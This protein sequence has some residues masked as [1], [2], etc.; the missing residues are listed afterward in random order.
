MKKVAIVLLVL[1]I[2]AGALYAKDPIFWKRF[3]TLLE[4]KIQKKSP[5]QWYAPLA[6]VDAQKGEALAT[7]KADPKLESAIDAA[8]AYV[9]GLNSSAFMV[10]QNGKLLRETYFNSTDEDTLIVSK[11]MAKPLASMLVARAIE[12]GFI[13][14][15]DQPASDFITEWQGKDKAAITV[16]HLLN[17]ASGLE[18]FYRNTAN[19]FS[20]FHQ[21]FLSSYHDEYIVNKVPLVEEPGSYYDYSQFTSDIVAILIERAT[22][23]KYQDYLANQLLKPIGAAGGDIWVNREGGVAHSGCCVM[24]PADTWLRLG[25]LLAQN[26]EWQGN[27]LLPDWWNAEILKGS[28]NNPNYGLYFWTGTPFAPRRHFVDPEYLPNPGI[29]QSQPYAAE[30]LFMFDGNGSQVI[31]I[32]P[33]KKLVVLRTGG[34]PPK[35]ADGNEWDNTIVPNTILAALEK[36]TG[37]A[38]TQPSF[39]DAM[40]TYQGLSRVSG[41]FETPIESVTSSTDFTDAIEHANKMSSYGLLVWHKGALKLEHYADGY[42]QSLRPETASMHK[43]VLAML[44]LAAVED[45][46]IKSLDDP[47]GD[48][49]PAWKDLPQGEIPLRSLLTMSSGLKPLSGEGGMNSPR[50]RFFIDGKNARTTILGLEAEVAWDSRFFYANTNSQLLCAA[51]EAA[52][53][54]PYASYLSERLWKPLGAQDAY[55]WNNEADGFPRTYASLLARPRDWLRLGLLIKDHGALAGEQILSKKS[56]EQLTNPS[57]RN[58]NY[59]LHIWLGREYEAM[60][61]YNDQNTGPAFASKVPFAVDDMIYFDGIGGQR[62]YVSRKQDLVI[63]RVGDMRFDWDDTHLPNLVIESLANNT[64]PKA[65]DQ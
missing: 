12:Q 10:W 35:D 7:G 55:V 64:K 46:F 57:A 38:S 47:I 36:P 63:V 24:L 48:Y 30:D 5:G 50:T 4:A 29:K 14:S 56:I 40:Q 16:R 13:D 51:L 58:P 26:G 15:L 59:G 53:S 43:S 33:S 19:P 8:Q 44:L 11:S 34:W 31:Y 9:A 27:R 41:K 18:R 1:A 22:K 42:D 37:G 60:R 52:S 20:S 6:K 62:V 28:A 23:Q 65:A 61:F 45:G 54:K 39:A 3:S 2:I 32:V 21:G 49:L 25:V 17:M